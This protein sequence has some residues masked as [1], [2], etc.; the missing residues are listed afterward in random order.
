M[1]KTQDGGDIGDAA[2]IETLPEPCGLVI[3]GA[4]GDLT[5]RKLIPALFSLFRRELMPGEF[6]I[7][8]CA[9]TPMTDEEFQQKTRDSILKRFGDVGAAEM[10]TFVGR[11][12]YH[13]GDYQ[14]SKTY[15]LLSERLKRLE[16][17][18]PTGGNRI[19]YL[20][21]PPS[22]YSPI[23][24]HLSSSGLT[25]ELEEGSP[26]VHIVVEKPYGRDLESAMKLDRDLHHSLAERQIYRIDHYLGKET[27]QNIL[28]FRFANAVFEPIWNRRYVD[29]IQITVAESIGV[30]HRAGYFEQAGLLRDM[31]QNHMLQMLTL[32]AMEPPTSFDADRVRDERVK[33]MR[34]IRPFPLE[35]IDR[36][37]IRGQYASSSV[38]G[39][40]VPGYRHE[41]GIADDSQVETFIAAKVF[42]D[43]WRWQGVPIYMR[44]GKRLERKTSEIAV[45]FKRVPHSMFASLAPNMLSPNVLVM[46]V[47]P[48]EGIALTIQ[49]KEPG[50]KLC[51]SSLTMDFR[52]HDIFGVELPDAYERLLLDCMLEDQTLFWRSDG[53]EASWSLVTP[54]LEKWEA[55][56]CPLAFYESG[57]W[58]PREAE[59]LLKRDGRQ[60]R[61]L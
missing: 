61:E 23:A 24:N 12:A 34:S 59:E 41:P 57:S 28:M 53:I 36:C 43:N 5:H 51:M 13:A 16:Q 27:V 4:S 42:I 31:F 30:E 17:Q 22:L 19:F 25:K 54:V 56:G 33:L 38:D 7:L 18:F 60:W 39:V 37:I 55:E 21:T 52:Y 1:D 47:Q 10:D 44:A 3:F 35:D 6:F 14:D 46:N 58:G 11:C 32:V 29:H 45:V 8:G 26:Y 50:A 48:E 49:A 9:R 15:D 40:A 20:A 2:C